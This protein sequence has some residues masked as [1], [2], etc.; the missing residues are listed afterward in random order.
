MKNG[1][2]LLEVQNCTCDRTQ[3]TADTERDYWIWQWAATEKGSVDLALGRYC[4]G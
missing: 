2:V 3:D 4:K 1:C